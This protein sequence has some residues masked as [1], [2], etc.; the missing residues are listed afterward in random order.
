ML[1]LQQ[2]VNIKVCAMIVAVAAI[3]TIAAVMAV[4][5]VWRMGRLVVGVYAVVTHFA[6]IAIQAAIV[7]ITIQ[8]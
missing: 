8:T 2:T 5:V 4:T 6:A 3:D 7:M 1:L